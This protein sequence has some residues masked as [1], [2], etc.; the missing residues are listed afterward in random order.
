M[1][2]HKAKR[3]NPLAQHNAQ[4]KPQHANPAPQARRRPNP[5][6]T[7]QLYEILNQLN[8]GYGTVLI[9][10]DNLELM[11][12]ATRPEVLPADCLRDLRN[13]TEE[14]R[15]LAN[16]ELLAVL[17]G[18]KERDAAHFGRSSKTAKRQA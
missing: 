17:A 2:V 6:A 9:S 3:S 13:R 18:H 5:L 1:A 10:L 16:R 12:T 15:A 8:R 4:P 11:N 14:L 7:P